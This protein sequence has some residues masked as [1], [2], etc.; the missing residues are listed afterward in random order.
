MTRCLMLDVDGVLIRGR[1]EDG[2]PW[3]TT[4]ATDLGIDPTRLQTAFFRPFWSQ[5][6]TGK[7]GLAETLAD[8]LPRIGAKVTA[9]DFIAYWFARD[10]RL[11]PEMLEDVGALR[12]KGLRVILCTNQDHLRAAY[13]MQDLGLGAHVDGIIYSATLGARKPEAAFFTAARAQT[14]LPPEA[15]L[16]IDDTRA[17]ITAA[18]KAGWRACLWQGDKRLCDC[19]AVPE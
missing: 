8:C 15:L 4:L 18:R 7:R 3:S 10:A 6:V 1:P 13:L 2:Q 19:V 17:N 16:L 5:I 12:A 9:K 14:G 11:D